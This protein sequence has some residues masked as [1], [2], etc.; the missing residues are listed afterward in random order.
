MAASGAI[1]TTVLKSLPVFADFSQVQ[2]H[3]L[4]GM[5]MRRAVPRG[6]AVMHEGD[7]ADSFYIVVSGRLKVML[8]EADGKETILSIL[9]PGECFG[10]MSLIDDQTR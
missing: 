10:E 4:V 2:L 8:G 1:S 5:V 6:S 3:A 9:G 7:P